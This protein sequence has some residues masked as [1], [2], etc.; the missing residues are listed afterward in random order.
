MPFMR[1]PN[2]ATGLRS[3][4]SPRIVP[5]TL[6]PP[7]D[8]SRVDA[9]R[10]RRE[11]SGRSFPSKLVYRVEQIDL[12]P[13]RGKGAEEERTIPLPRECDRKG[14]GTGGVHAPLAPVGGDRFE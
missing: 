12:G 14:A 4:K 11:R 13:E 5:W 8:T 9:C 7:H 10:Q 3:E 2:R 1:A 6:L